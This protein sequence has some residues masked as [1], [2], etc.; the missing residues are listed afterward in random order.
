MASSVPTHLDYFS[1]TIS[2]SLNFVPIKSAS[3]LSQ[4]HHP[5]KTILLTNS[6]ISD[7]KSSI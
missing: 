3:W 2:S 7:Q 4:A 6:S 1:I 5:P